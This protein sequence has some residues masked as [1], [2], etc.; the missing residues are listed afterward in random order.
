M[1]VLKYYYIV[2]KRD[3]VNVK[4]ATSSLITTNTVIFYAMGAN[5]FSKLAYTHE[6]SI[7][8]TIILYDIPLVVY[9]DRVPE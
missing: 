2:Y 6:M 5:L 8:L 7:I 9:T 1:K 4:T 3:V